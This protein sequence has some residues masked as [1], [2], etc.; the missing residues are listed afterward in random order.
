MPI[1]PPGQ[2][3]RKRLKGARLPTLFKVAAAKATACQTLEVADWYGGQS[4]T[5]D[6]VTATALWYHT[7]KKPVAIRW[8][9]IRLKDKL[10]G[11]VSNDPSLR[12]DEMIGYFV[13]C[14]SMETTFAL[15]RAQLGVET[16]RQWSDLA[17]SRTT[18]VLMGLFSLV[19]LLANSLEKRG[20]LVCQVSS[21]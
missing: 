3:G 21:W 20:Q 12:A 5:V 19:S 2:R 18:A 9:W 4:Q 8:V 14:W 17:I 16:Q 6:Y 15:V 1:P 11:L 13:R 10:T 7:G